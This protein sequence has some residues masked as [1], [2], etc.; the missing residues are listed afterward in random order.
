LQSA[1]PTLLENLHFWHRVSEAV[2]E[3]VSHFGLP[4]KHAVSCEPCGS[5]NRFDHSASGVMIA[6][7]SPL[8][9]SPKPDYFDPVAGPNS[10]LW[11]AHFV[12]KSQ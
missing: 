6:K 5:S 10:F 1:L 4:G 11:F 12:A 3:I 2:R 7:P 9:R 8:E